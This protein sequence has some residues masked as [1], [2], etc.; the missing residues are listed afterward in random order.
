MRFHLN[1]ETGRIGE[2]RAE[3]GHCP[4]KSENGSEFQ[5]F[6]SL[7][8]ARGCYEEQMRS[9]LFPDEGDS[10][11]RFSRAL[12]RAVRE[13]PILSRIEAE[14]GLL[15]SRFDHRNR[16]Q[17]YIRADIIYR[18]KAD[19]AK[20]N[21]DD[22]R[23][24]GYLK[25]S[26]IS[27]YMTQAEM[28]ASYFKISRSERVES[29]LARN[30]RAA[31]SEPLRH[32]WN[33]DY[34]NEVREDLEDSRELIRQS[35]KVRTEDGREVPFDRAVL[36]SDDDGR[37]V[38]LSP[39]SRRKVMETIRHN[40]DDLVD[41]IGGELPNPNDEEIQCPEG[42]EFLDSGAEGVVYLH[43]RT[44]IVYKIPHTRNPY[45]V[46]SKNS[47]DDMRISR[48]L[49][50]LF[51]KS[52]KDSR[53]PPK[54]YKYLPT[55]PLTAGERRMGIT[56]QPYMDPARF[57]PYTIV[58]SSQKDLAARGYNDLHEGNISA[59]VRTGIVYMHDCLTWDKRDTWKTL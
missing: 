18:Q 39:E 40:A 58:G 56:A 13:N 20:L 22:D 31:I 37:P 1:T 57:D 10:L 30:I 11:T 7:Q 45:F 28:T 6:S 54:G 34:L 46:G 29:Y 16:S 32:G 5:H 9:R 17:S 43:R 23:A 59:D 47:E 50:K 24:E 55:F 21:G 4:L 14:D 38:R 41:G 3:P 27:S 15:T 48:R 8:E 53:K 44:M 52:L 49:N 35:E 26:T 25:L 19:E 36:G 51:R 33:T 42:F 12:H 2:C